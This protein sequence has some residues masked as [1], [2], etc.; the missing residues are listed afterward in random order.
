M[1]TAFD[2]IKIAGLCV[3]LPK[4]ILEINSLAAEFG[5]KKIKRTIALTGVEKIHIADER[6]TAAD[7]C[8]K[9]A[10]RL[11]GSLSVKCADVDGLVF[12]SITPD[13]RAPATSGI[14]QHKLGLSRNTAAFDINGGCSGYILG[15]YQAAMLLSAGGCEKVLV[16][17][18]DTQ[19]KLVNA[20]D[21]SLRVLLRAAGSATLLEKGGGKVHFVLKT[22]GSGYAHIIIPAGGTRLPY[23]PQTCREEVDG[24]GNI[25]SPNNICMNGLE[26]LKFALQEVPPLIEEILG[27]VGWIKDDVGIFALHQANGVILDYLRREM[28]LSHEVMPTAMRT[29]GNTSSASIP[30]LLV[31]ERER[32]T[33]E[34]R[35]EKAVLSGFGVG[36]SWGAAALDMAG[37]NILDAI[38][39]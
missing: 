24:N 32:L 9:A 29:V 30:L 4:N 14:M 35:L 21:H 31:Q 10:E 34:A 37:T 38:Y 23:S 20:K 5:E 19:S 8:L 1:K 6:V 3:C 39:Y 33:R 16:C 7:L 18:G 13:Y 11:M 2:G 26:V 22:D 15:L 27:M 36:L 17:C 25:R 12:V 28:R